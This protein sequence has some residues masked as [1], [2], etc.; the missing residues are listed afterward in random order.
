MVLTPPPP[1]TI[2]FAVAQIVFRFALVAAA[3]Q[4]SFHV[5][6]G[7]YPVTDCCVPAAFVEFQN[8]VCLPTS[9]KSVPPTAMLNGVE[10]RPLTARPWFA[11]VAVLKSSQPAEPGSP[12]ETNTVMPC[13]A[14]CSHNAF[15][16]A[17][18]APKPASQAPKLRLMMS[19]VLLSTAYKEDNSNPPDVR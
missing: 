6:S 19:S 12:A 1:P 8:M 14:A 16:K 4:E 18:S 2:L 5:V 7:I 10:A 9:S 11:T 13:A 15:K 3:A 17:F